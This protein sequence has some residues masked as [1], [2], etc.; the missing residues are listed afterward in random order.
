MPGQQ[1]IRFDQTVIFK[2]RTQIP[3]QIGLNIV[4][5]KYGNHS[6][7]ANNIITVTC[8]HISNA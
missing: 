1:N 7:N 4:V 2:P 6:N 8:R 5:T 3:R